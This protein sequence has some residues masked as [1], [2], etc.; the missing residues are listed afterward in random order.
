V[1]WLTLVLALFGYGALVVLSPVIALWGDTAVL[2][3]ILPVL[4][5]RLVFD[6]GLT[7]PA[8]LITRKMEFR[9]IALRTTVANGI[10]AVLCIWMVIH[11]YA[12]WALVL[13]QVVTSFVALVV[14]LFAAGWRPKLAFSL[15]AL[16]ELRSFGLYSMGGR[17]LNEARIDQFLLGMLLGPPVLGL[18]YFARRLFLMLCDVTVGVFTPI[19]G[20]LLASLQSDVEKRRQAYL[21]A[22][23]A[24][25]SLAFP[26][27]TGL[28]AIAPTAVP[29]LFG[30][31]WARAVFPVQ[32]LS[33]IGIMAGLG[34][35]QAS[36]IRNLGKPGWWFK[37]QAV[38]QLSALPIILLLYPFGLD[39]ILGALVL[40]TLVFWPASVRMAHRMLDMSLRT[41]LGRLSGP[42]FGS[43][44][45]SVAV[46]SVPDFW[47]LINAGQT[48]FAQ[49]LTGAIVYTVVLALTS[50]RRLR[51]IF[52]IIR[53][54][55]TVPQ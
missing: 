11:G 20:V 13:S 23:Y 47:P 17:L 10:G 30:S 43:A 27:F 9:V 40:R 24:S 3:A 1:F 52:D 28:I 15:S 22:S 18:Y 32:C 6:A 53:T 31:Q 16:R 55:Q 21:M 51:E 37:Y 35:M 29:Y 2:K 34:I 48:I 14:T 41:Y 42:A 26:V 49:V 44:L 36:L 54:R 33:V 7:V 4:A 12:L 39:T 38:S 8:A 5:L 45:M 19:T 46:T 25:A 50:H